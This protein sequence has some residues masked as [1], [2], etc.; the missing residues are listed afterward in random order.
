MSVSAHPYDQR[1]ARQ[2]AVLLDAHTHLDGRDPVLDLL[3]ATHGPAR[4]PSPAPSNR[5]FHDLAES[6]AYQQL[7]G[8]AAATIWG[9]VRAAAGEDVVTPQ[10]LLDLGTDPLRAAGLSGSKTR[11]M[12]DLSQHV[13]SGQITLDRIGR[14]G[15]EEV[16]Q[17][18]VP[19]WGIGRWTA[20]MFL[21]FTLGRLDVWPVGDYGVRAGY[22]KAWGL[23]EMPKEKEMEALGLPFEGARSLVAWYCWRAA[24]SGESGRS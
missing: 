14:L 20:Q 17:Q 24:D 11:S 5:R 3:M 9:R 1:M 10:R 23:V 15:D 12:L 22:G 13:V 16:I 18:L 6:I 2:R 21:M 7:N 8:T 19:V 4:L